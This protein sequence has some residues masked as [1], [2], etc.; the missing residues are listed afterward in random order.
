M[1]KQLQHSLENLTDHPIL[2]WSGGKDSMLLLFLLRQMYGDFPVLVFP[3]WWDN[4]EFITQIV[5]EWDLT[6]YSYRPSK[7]EASDKHIV[8]YYQIGKKMLPVVTD[9]LKSNKC[10]LDKA[11]NVLQGVIPY[12]EWDTVITG[13]KSVDKHSLIE[14]L[15]FTNT[16]IETPLWDWTDEE[17]F[18]AINRLS[19]PIDHRIY[20]DGQEQYDTA[21]WSGCMD[22]QSSRE[23]YCYKQNAIIKG[24]YYGIV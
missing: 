21:N 23:V 15:N 10:G 9:V 19:V 4:T 11:N 22:C 1:I 2:A 7:L 24:A 20:S 3:H 13:S 17:V 18:D 14:K 12:F 16:N 8:T 5:K 6:A